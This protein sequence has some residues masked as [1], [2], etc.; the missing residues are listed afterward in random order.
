MKKNELSRSKDRAPLSREIILRRALDIIDEKGIKKLSMRTLGSDLGVEAMSL[1]NHV[2]NKDDIISG[3][4]DLIVQEI[5]VPDQDSD[6]RIAMELFALSARAVLKKHPWAGLLMDSHLRAGPA[7]LHYYDSVIGTFYRAGFS[8]EQA[9]RGFSLIDSYIYGFAV[10]QAGLES[11]GNSSQMERTDR[12]EKF[13][14]NIPE[15]SYPYL[16][17]IT[18]WALENSYDPEEDFLFG[19][20]LILSGLEELLSFKK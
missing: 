4:L 15:K 7:R 18:E 13:Q 1:Y 16:S 12:V 9:A 3:V 2:R 17:K 6:W 8:I 20:N 14:E 19:I 10:Q 11:G 5:S